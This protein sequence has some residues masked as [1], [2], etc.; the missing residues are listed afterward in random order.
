M[1]WEPWRDKLPQSVV[2]KIDHY[3]AKT[4]EPKII[5]ESTRLVTSPHITIDAPHGTMYKKVKIT[6]EVVE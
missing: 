2:N 4:L 6:I 3:R 1:G 5:H